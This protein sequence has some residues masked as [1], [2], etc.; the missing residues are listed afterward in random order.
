M[1][2]PADNFFSAKMMTMQF[3]ALKDYISNSNIDTDLRQSIQTNS[4]RRCSTNNINEIEKWLTN[5]W[6][7]ENILMM[8]EHLFADQRNAFA[9]QWIFPQAYYSCFCI[10]LGFF[11]TAGFSEYRHSSVLKK[12]GYLIK[13]GKYPRFISFFADGGMYQITFSGVSRS[14]VGSTVDYDPSDEAS[15]KNQIAQFLNATRKNDLKAKKKDIRILTKRGKKKDHYNRQD[16]ERV[17]E[18]LG[19]TNILSLLYRKRIKFNYD[20]IE[21]VFNAE[22]D[23]TA[24]YN[25]ILYLVSKINLTHEA[26]IFKI[27]GEAEYRR[28][29]NLQ[30]SRPQLR[31]ERFDKIREINNE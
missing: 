10:T 14:P 21:S 28:I 20:N 9:I 8:S 5:G 19:P 27:L 24:I 15:I 11:K 3:K 7:T 29:I 6:N 17:S 25:S 18:K 4:F 22:L 31:N 16:W 13:E 1:V 26:H 23:A 2:D 30:S 12:L